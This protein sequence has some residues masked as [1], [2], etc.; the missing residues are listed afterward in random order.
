MERGFD[1][2]VLGRVSVLDRVSRHTEVLRAGEYEFQVELNGTRVG[3]KLDTSKCDYEAWEL[4]GIPCVHALACINTMRAD[5][6]EYCSPYF[7]AK[8]WRKS[9]SRVVHP[10]PSM[11]LWP[12]IKI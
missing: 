8:T 4:R 1:S 3:V 9:F 11:H 5:V 10:I 12:P 7:K 2:D 6:V